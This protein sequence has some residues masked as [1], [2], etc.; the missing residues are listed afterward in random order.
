MWWDWAAH[1]L[2]QSATQVTAETA[3]E[4]TPG[5]PPSSLMSL[6][7]AKPA[8]A[9]VV[10]ADFD[11]V[12]TNTYYESQLDNRSNIDP[13]SIVAAAEVAA[14]GLHA[15]AL[16]NAEAAAGL[17]VPSQHSQHPCKRLQLTEPSQCLEPFH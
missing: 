6:L 10:L 15:L 1:H 2:T 4:E 8:I 17:E 9:G 12:F 16:G 13:A 7:R 14:R 3:S 11:A 5:I